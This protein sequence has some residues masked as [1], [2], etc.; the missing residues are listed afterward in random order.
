MQ[1]HL[2]MSFAIG[3]ADNIILLYMAAS[4]SALSRCHFKH[5]TCFI[6]FKKCNHTC[7]CFR[8]IVK[9]ISYLSNRESTCYLFVF[10][11]FSQRLDDE[12]FARD[13]QES[14]KSPTLY[15]AV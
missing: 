6:Y 5:S 3:P 1:N 15:H 10:G 7:R 11:S 8:L 13:M 2:K 12:E 9:R 14:L 4:S